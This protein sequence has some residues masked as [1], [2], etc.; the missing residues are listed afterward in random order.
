MRVSTF[1]GMMSQVLVTVNKVAFFYW[2]W[3]PNNT[4]N[5]HSLLLC[6]LTSIGT[7]LDI[8]HFL[9]HYI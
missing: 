8:V 9:R 6:N 3:L 2:C 4:V 1:V 5:S 7:L